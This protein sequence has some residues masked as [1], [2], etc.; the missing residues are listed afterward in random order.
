MGKKTPPSSEFETILG[1]AQS[2]YLAGRYEE[3]IDVYESIDVKEGLHPVML[4][5]M[6]NAYS[7]INDHESASLALDNYRAQH[8]LA[9][10][11]RLM[12]RHEEAR[13]EFNLFLEK[14]G[15]AYPDVALK[16]RYALRL[17]EEEKKNVEGV[18]RQGGRG[19]DPR[20]ETHN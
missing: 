16:V 7:K 13:R 17:M 9:Q 12:G 3:A 1:L 2:H 4:E 14:Y 20:G 10:T 11:L 5:K 18:V 19:G 8:N 6:A 15:E